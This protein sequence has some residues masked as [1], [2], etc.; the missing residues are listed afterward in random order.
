MQLRALGAGAGSRISGGTWWLLI[1]KLV[2]QGK[3]KVV[4]I[5]QTAFA[6]L[7]WCQS[8]SSGERT[9]LKTNGVTGQFPRVS[10]IH[11]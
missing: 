3:L 7:L 8:G 11:V 9:S 10:A 2:L 5:L 1:P 6:L 4:N